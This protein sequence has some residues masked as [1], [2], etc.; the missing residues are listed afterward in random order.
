MSTDPPGGLTLANTPQFVMLSFDG[1]ITT[2]TIANYTT[3]LNNR[4][5][6]NG[7]PITMSFNVYHE[8][9]DYNLTHRLYYMGQEINTHSL[10]HTI[11]SSD[12]ID[13]TTQQW[14]DEIGGMQTILSKFANI[15]ASS[16]RGVKAPFLQTS[17]D[18]TFQAMQ[19]VPNT[20]FDNSFPTTKQTNPPIWPYTLDQGFQHDCTIPPCPGNRYPGIWTVPMISVTDKNGTQ[21]A[22]I[23]SC[24]RPSNQA[25][26]YN[27]LR[28]NFL[29]HYTTSKAPYGVYLQANAWFQTTTYNFAAY[30]QFLDYLGTLDDVYIVSLGKVVDWM[31]NPVPLS[32]LPN[33]PTFQCPYMPPSICIPRNCYYDANTTPV[34]VNADRVM[35]SCTTCPDLYPWTGNPL[36]TI[37]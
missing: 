15:P 19:N 21:C 20:L 2:T 30:L 7:C 3:I 36:G 11:P 28:D 27:Y 8:F 16:I 6:P 32:Q 35:M 1:A 10:S 5:N 24:P 33:S 4:L 23:D 17:G 26:A 37:N 34:D 14:I 18:A 22:M 25:E 31:R 9:N 13:K 29:R 12:W